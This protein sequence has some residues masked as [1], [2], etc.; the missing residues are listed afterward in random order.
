M[1]M[2]VL[3]VLKDSV[4]ITAS[5][6]WVSCGQD[7]VSRC[8]VMSGDGVL[9]L[10]PVCGRSCCSQLILGQLSSTPGTRHCTLHGEDTSRYDC[11]CFDFINVTNNPHVCAPFSRISRYLEYLEYLVWW[12]KS[13]RRK[14]REGKP[15][16]VTVGHF[17][18]LACSR[19]PRQFHHHD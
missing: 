2:N 3:K 12:R 13:G 9:V 4:N 18:L 5:N 11:S 16:Y 17:W 14:V 1:R 10:S 7:P 8:H 15:S 6:C 19:N